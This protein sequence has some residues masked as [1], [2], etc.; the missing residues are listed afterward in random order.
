MVESILAFGRCIIQVRKNGWKQ[1]LV[2]LVVRNV[3]SNSMSIS[4]FFPQA[5]FLLCIQ[6]PL[7]MVFSR[8]KELLECFALNRLEKS[9]I[10]PS[11]RDYS[12]NWIT[13][14]KA[15]YFPV[16]VSG[17]YFESFYQIFSLLTSTPK[18]DSISRD[19]IEPSL[20]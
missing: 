4:R 15:I 6:S 8:N 12:C 3:L 11:L 10:L 7:L 5:N 19:S 1:D 16:I 13:L 2:R 14:L 9:S 17:A 18:L 20:S